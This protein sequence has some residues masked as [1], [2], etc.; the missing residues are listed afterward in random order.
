MRRTRLIAVIALGCALCA[1]LHAFDKQA[2]DKPAADKHEDKS[3]A[4]AVKAQK[5]ET[6]GSV[7]VEGK[8]LDYKAIA[9]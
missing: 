8:K 6:A 2:A 7:S 4:P 9:G 5:V 3:A 1:P